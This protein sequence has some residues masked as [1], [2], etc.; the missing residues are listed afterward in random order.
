MFLG[1]FTNVVRHAA[2][3]EV[4]AAKVDDDDLKISVEDNGAGFGPLPHSSPGLAGMRER[5]VDLGG[6]LTI[7]SSLG[8]GTRMQAILPLDSDGE[9]S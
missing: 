8:N 9:A 5:A 6:Q 7:E 4:R 1:D 3:S 2:A